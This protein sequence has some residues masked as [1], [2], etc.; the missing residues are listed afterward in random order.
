M[1]YAGGNEIKVIHD[2]TEEMVDY[3]NK[4]DCPM[5]GDYIKTHSGT[6][7]VEKVLYDFVEKIMVLYCSESYDLV[8]GGYTES[9]PN[10]IRNFIL[11]RNQETTSK[12]QIVK[13]VKE[14]FNLGLKEAKDYVDALI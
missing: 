13:D 14:T 12:L 6:Y 11:K 7:I 2:N 5:E 1:I 8:N 10:A 3:I 9:T 4:D